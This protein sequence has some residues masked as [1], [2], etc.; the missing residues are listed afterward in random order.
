MVEH[1]RLLP[2][3][4]RTSNPNIRNLSILSSVCHPVSCCSNMACPSISFPASSSSTMFWRSRVNNRADHRK[5]KTLKPIA[6]AC[7]L[8]LSSSRKF[9][10]H[11]PAFP[12]LVAD[13]V[14][15]LYICQLKIDGKCRYRLDSRLL[16]D[17]VNLT[18]IRAFANHHA[19]SA[20][21]V[22]AREQRSPRVRAGVNR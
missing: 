13:I 10:S 7:L 21:R 15:Q 9:H 19:C 2:V 8:A 22:T 11:L 1:G 20:S 12:P 17:E 3:S 16:M 18:R 5:P 14:I 6:L 4:R